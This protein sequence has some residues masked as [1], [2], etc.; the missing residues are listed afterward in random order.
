M[1][2]PTRKQPAAAALP[3]LK[4]VENIT[5]REQV[6]QAVRTA[7]MHGHLRP[8]QPV[9]VKSISTMVGASVM[10]AREAMNRLIAEGALELRPNRTVIV[11]DLTRQEFDELTD[12]R[13][14]IEA[15][16]AAHAVQRVTREDIARLEA[17]DAAM[18]AAVPAADVD[19]Y[20]SKNFEFHFQIYQ[21]GTSKFFLSIIEKLWVRVGPL[22]RF[23]LDESGFGPSTRLHALVIR[24]LQTQDSG[25]LRDAIQADINGAAQSIR[26]AREVAKAW[27]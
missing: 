17:L 10:P 21:L 15:Q 19:T 20:L 6:T 8:G 22:I 9:T 26:A 5:L 13:C 16:A 1:N 7:L 3:L 23:S 4:P 14:H 27:H 2:M 12:L 11:P 18:H 25:M 24:G